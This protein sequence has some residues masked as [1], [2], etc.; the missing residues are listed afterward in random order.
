MRLYRLYDGSAHWF[1][2][3]TDD[4]D[5]ARE[6]ANQDDEVMEWAE[7]VAPEDVDWEVELDVDRAG[8]FRFSPCSPHS[9]G[10][11]SWHLNNANGPGRGAF[12]GVYFDVRP[13]E[14]E[15]D[16]DLDIED[17]E[18]HEQSLLPAVRA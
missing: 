16:T 7:E 8:W 15:Y 6:V 17:N 12:L 1:L 14:T 9:C 4:V 2:R 13:V 18:E 3:G 10:D 5:V 11:H